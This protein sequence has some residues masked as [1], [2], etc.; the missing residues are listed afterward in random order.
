MEFTARIVAR[1][2]GPGA[3]AFDVP[4]WKLVVE[5]ETEGPAMVLMSQQY[6]NGPISGYCERWRLEAE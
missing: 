3:R 2:A 1:F 5:G 4:P 6:L